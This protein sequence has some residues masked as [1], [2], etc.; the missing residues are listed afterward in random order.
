MLR[1]AVFAGFF[2]FMTIAAIVI[3]WVIEKVDKWKQQRR[4]KR[5][6]TFNE[7]M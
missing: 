1:E 7:Q 4:L 2:I 3:V 6:K 5:A